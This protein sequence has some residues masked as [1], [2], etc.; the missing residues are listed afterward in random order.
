M[1]A[2]K[3]G[4]CQDEHSNYYNHL[5][6]LCFH[7]CFPDQQITCT[8]K[9][10]KKSD[11]IMSLHVN[12]HTSF[13]CLKALALSKLVF[14]KKADLPQNGDLIFFLNN[15]HT[16]ELISTQKTSHK[17]SNKDLSNCWWSYVPFTDLHA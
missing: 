8:E 5:G 7:G 10:R 3:R 1:R 13:S 15:Q 17:H 2:F 14:S 16:R 11:V 12:V 9:R 4:K 6:R